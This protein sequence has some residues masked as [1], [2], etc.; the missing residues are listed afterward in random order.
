METVSFEAI[1]RIRQHINREEKQKELLK[2]LQQWLKLTSALDVLE[3]SSWAVE[4]YCDM[5]YPADM[6]GKYLYTYGLL[7]A[8]FLQQDAINSISQALFGN[9]INY[10]ENYP[11]AYKVRELRN[12]VVGHPTNRGGNR[13]I[14]LA[15]IHMEKESFFYI[16]EDSANE[17][18][19]GVTVDVFAAISDS[20]KCINNILKDSLDAL[21]SEFREYIDEHRGKKMKDIFDNLGYAKEKVMLNTTIKDW[22]YNATKDMVKKCEIE[23][24]QRYGSSDTLDSYKYLLG[25]IHTVFELIDIGLPR[26]P[27]D[28]YINIEKCLLENLF[29]KLNELKSYCAETDEI[30]ENYGQPTFTDDGTTTV[31][32][33]DNI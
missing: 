16:D 26:I 21:D 24:E 31:V 22:G 2:K 9:S 13:F 17:S 23:L 25:S 20:A 19:N 3:D 11:K 33:V 18:N 8:L 27:S 30:F 4:Y 32:I 1:N 29:A 12:D 5:E 10:K 28:L 15:Q 14:Y 7:Q 6:R